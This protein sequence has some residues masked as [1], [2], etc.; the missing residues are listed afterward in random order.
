[1]KD[2]L[3]LILWALAI[4][5][6]WLFLTSMTGLDVWLK[7]LVGKKD[8]TAMLEAKVDTLEKRAVRLERPH[9]DAF[10]LK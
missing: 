6:A 4:G 1:M 5:F 10:V 7:Q 3:D 9:S 2:P 8:R